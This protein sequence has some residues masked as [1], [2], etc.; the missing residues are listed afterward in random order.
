M[1]NYQTLLVAIGLAADAFAVSVATG[2]SEKRV[3]LKHALTMS[4]SFGIFQ[5]GMPVAG[6]LLASVFHDIISA[7]AHWIAFVLLAFIGGKMIY[8]GFDS[9]E[10]EREKN[11]FSFGSILMLSLATSLDALAVGISYAALGES[12]TAPAIAIGIVTFVLSFLGIE[13]GKRFGAAIG[14][15]AEI[16]G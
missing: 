5:A 12:I 2:I 7:Y 8:E 14:S 6:Y 3:P 1:F 9:G 13:F 4:L 16:V 10:E 15:K 11:I